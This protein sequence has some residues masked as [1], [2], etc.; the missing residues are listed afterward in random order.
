MHFSTIF[1]VSMYVHGVFTVAQN[2]CRGNSCRLQSESS[3][4]VSTAPC[5]NDGIC[6]PVDGSNRRCFCQRGFSGLHCEVPVDECSLGFCRNNATCVPASSFT[7]AHCSCSKFFSGTYCEKPVCE[8]NPCQNSGICSADSILGFRCACTSGFTGTKCDVDIDE[9]RRTPS[10]CLG[11]G[12]CRNTF[13]SYQCDCLA[14]YTGD[15]CE[16]QLCPSQT[17][18]SCQNG[19]CLVDNTTS[20]GIRCNCS[21]GFTGEFCDINV[22]DCEGVH[23][24]GRGLCVDEIAQYRC[25]CLPGWTGTNCESRIDE[26]S[27]N[28]CHPGSTCVVRSE[29][30]YQ[31]LCTPGMDGRFC[32]QQSDHCH[33]KPCGPHGVCY[34]DP[35]TSS[36]YLCQCEDRWTGVNCSTQIPVDPCRTNLCR[37]NGICRTSTTSTSQ[38]ATA[39]NFICLCPPDFGGYYCDFHVGGCNTR[40]PRC[41]NGGTCLD[42]MGNI[43]CLCTAQ[44]TGA[45]CEYPVA[46]PVVT[47][48]SPN[49]IAPATVPTPTPM[50]TASTVKTTSSTLTTLPTVTL[51]QLM[52]A[53]QTS[54]S[55]STTA[56]ASTLPPSLLP[57]FIESV[58]PLGATT[59]PAA[60]ALTTQDSIPL[61]MSEADNLE[62]VLASTRST[63]TQATPFPV[64]GS[65][66]A[67]TIPRTPL[68]GA[69]PVTEPPISVP[70]SPPEA[71]TVTP[72]PEMT[73]PSTSLPNVVAVSEQL[74]QSSNALPASVEVP[75]AVRYSECSSIVCR[76][77]GT[78][79][80]T[81][82]NSQLRC[83]CPLRFFGDLCEDEVLITRPEF[84]ANGYLTYAG[85]SALPG[86]TIAVALRF[87]SS[88]VP[89]NATLAF[90]AV[91]LNQFVRLEQVNYTTVRLISS[92]GNGNEPII[93]MVSSATPV[94]IFT[95]VSF[96]Q[97][98]PTSALPMCSA[99]L[100][101]ETHVTQTNI[102]VSS[103]SSDDPTLDQLYIGGSPG[104]STNFTGV[105][106][107][108][109]VNGKEMRF[110]GG[111]GQKISGVNVFQA[112]PKVCLT[113][114]PCQNNGICLELET[115]W[116]CA[117]AHGFTGTLCELANCLENPCWSGST[118]IPPTNTSL[119]STVQCVCPIGRYGM[120]CENA[121]D[122]Q[123]DLRY[124]GRSATYSSFASFAPLKITRDYVEISFSF[125]ISTSSTAVTQ[126]GTAAENSIL[127]IIGNP[128]HIAMNFDFILI[129]LEGLTPCVFYNL[130]SGFLKQTA[131]V[132][133]DAMVGNHSLSVIVDGSWGVSLALDSTSP[134]LGMHPANY[135]FT[136]F[137][138]FMP[139]SV[140]GYDTMDILPIPGFG[141]F[142]GTITDIKFRT[143]SNASFVVLT[144]LTGGRNVLPANA[145]DV[146]PCENREPLCGDDTCLSY[147]ASYGCA[148]GSARAADSTCAAISVCR[149]AAGSKC[150]P[151]AQCVPDL[152]RPNEGY[153][154]DCPI[155][156]TGE[157]CE[158]NTAGTN[159]PI[160]GTNSPIAGTNSPIAGT[161]SPMF[162]G[163]NSFMG[164]SET[165]ALRYETNLQVRIRPT[166]PSGLIYYVAQFSESRSV[167]FLSLFLSDGIINF[168]FNLGDSVTK[169]ISSSPTDKV[170]LGK[171]TSVEA[172]RNSTAAWLSVNGRQV[173]SLL[174][175]NSLHFLDVFTF[176]Y[177]GGLPG[178]MTPAASAI[179]EDVG[180][181]HGCLSDLYVNDK[182]YDLS[183]QSPDLKDGRNIDYCSGSKCNPEVEICPAR[184]PDQ[185]SVAQCRS[186]ACQGG[187]LCVPSSDGARDGYS[188]DCS[189]GRSGR[190]CENVV[191]GLKNTT[192][193]SFSDG[194]QLVAS[195]VDY[196]SSN[197]SFGYV[198]FRFRTNLSDCLMLWTGIVLTPHSD[199][200]GVGLKSGYLLVVWNLGW[201]SKR[202][203][204][205]SGQR[206][207]DG[208]WHQVTIS[209]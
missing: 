110:D 82:G 28:E 204:V 169:S 67:F 8:S 168:R 83:D 84:R 93:L 144:E 46:F 129:G 191:D 26:C 183:D 44:F 202:E 23:C 104:A 22:D 135:P 100:K 162:N 187:S 179:I 207:D 27:N 131:R 122:L 161:N 130:G 87:A 96:K 80:V 12:Q 42:G 124:F 118:C 138:D 60:L 185:Q 152:T 71:I 200:L 149:S 195:D 103:F 16:Y 14:P 120:Y 136:G 190:F 66:K 137:D 189:V 166:S 116:M 113:L 15:H 45:R 68:L 160:A 121:Y 209:R 125:S 111:T 79:T 171:W 159:S 59:T 54:T 114:R 64:I 41:L 127:L 142:S 34:T 88:I 178:W 63:S 198:S 49:T 156:R 21:F 47:A 24:S 148:C 102:S 29:G 196:R 5:L 109:A 134:I 69:R 17:M 182:M 48:P 30:G 74:I 203:M 143:A 95:T 43:T 39:D 123:T 205:S 170:E 6:W 51:P 119:Q 163:E 53:Q 147:G 10:I 206:F 56:G 75:A 31:C 36:G 193:F 40:T 97:Q 176:Q 164:L 115:G 73:I 81:E 117:C 107:N 132:S 86:I 167:D 62:G 145:D 158:Q 141:G 105:I 140:G 186:N 35:A 154:C 139:V 90:A 58:V 1:I 13:G 94:T 112:S 172:G 85:S 76:N 188:C 55:A 25:L 70:T 199:Y 32:N 78:C 65:A 175:N 19:R 20:S 150:D 77:G 194:S 173:A 192:A 180:S 50:T 177:L 126:T 174:T 184:K 155:G 7:G 2:V 11:F 99:V 61:D 38:S 91:G 146:S 4:D 133:V 201:I 197:K 57:V 18:N 101:W 9:C 108:V 98:F 72:V 153:R 151:R 128:E 92:C 208:L 157:F 52:P 37:N 3:C 33:D 181:F 89:S 106:T 165:P